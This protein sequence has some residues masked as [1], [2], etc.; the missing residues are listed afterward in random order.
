MFGCFLRKFKHWF[1]VC[2]LR[3]KTHIQSK[4]SSSLIGKS[5][6]VSGCIPIFLAKARTSSVIQTPPK[7]RSSKSDSDSISDPNE[8]CSSS[9]KSWVKVYLCLTSSTWRKERRVSNLGFR[10]WKKAWVA[11]RSHRDPTRSAWPTTCSDSINP[12]P[13]S[14]STTP[15]SSTVATPISLSTGS[16]GSIHHA[17]KPEA[18][19][20][21]YVNDIGLGILDQTE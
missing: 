19:G 12:P 14:L 17:K 11:R 21:C 13:A 2:F 5:N 10:W 8:W 15:S 16:V 18:S 6:H 1:S 3:K 4:S 9:S 7:P 20:F